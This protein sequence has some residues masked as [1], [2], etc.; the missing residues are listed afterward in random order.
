MAT[1]AQA[2]LGGAYASIAV[3]R[4]HLGAR[5]QSTATATYTLHTLTLA[6]R[7]IVKEFTRADGTVF[8]ITWRGPGRPDL[9]QLLGAHFDTL[10]ADNATQRGPRIRRPLSVNRPDFVVE[11]GGHSGACW[12]VAVLPQLEPSGFS[13]SDLN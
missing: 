4:A 6:N 2:A 1:A 10:Q 8:A 12:G 13:L 3:D 7:G 5:V 9:R 11:S